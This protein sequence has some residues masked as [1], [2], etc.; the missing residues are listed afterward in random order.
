MSRTDLLP[1]RVHSVTY[2]AEDVR[3][4]ELRSPAGG[5]LPRYTAGAHLDV[6]LPGGIERSYSLLDPGLEPRRYRIGVQRSATS[7]GGSAFMFEGLKVGDIIQVTAPS[8]SFELFEEAPLS[9][10]IAGGIGITPL[11]CMV[12]RL[13]QLGRRWQLYYATRTRERG[14]FLEPLRQLESRSP[15]RLVTVFDQEP[16]ASM[17]D[18][19]AIVASHGPHAHFY[20]CGPA[21]MLSAFEA[22]T[23]AVPASQVHVEYFSAMQAP[24]RGGFEVVLSRSGTT[25]FVPDDSTILQTLLARG[26]EVP[27]SCMSGVCGTCETAVLEG[28]P[29]HR[30]QV[31]SDRERASNKKMMICCSG[32]LGPRLVLDL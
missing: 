23:A 13:E 9:V 28:E 1:V 22:A 32:S 5:D 17:L 14:A 10:L 20:C 25:L 18:L 6:L 8:N 19:R 4:F 3:S 27:R 21:G 11:W 2:E 7:R 30:D 15:G 26:L 29:D 16:G 12:Q 24:A 31:L